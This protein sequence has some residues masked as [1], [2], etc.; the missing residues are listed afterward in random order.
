L[1]PRELKIKELRD[2]VAASG[3]EIKLREHELRKEKKKKQGSRRL[4]MLQLG[5]QGRT[6]GKKAEEDCSTLEPEP[7]SLLNYLGLETCSLDFVFRHAK[8]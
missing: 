2:D 5:K 3:A 4:S 1:Y 8:N 7:H 6:C